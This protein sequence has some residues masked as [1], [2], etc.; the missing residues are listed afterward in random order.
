[1]KLRPVD[2]PQAD[3]LSTVRRLVDAVNRFADA[4]VKELAEATGFSERHVR[5]RLA[6]ARAL[7]LMTANRASLTTRGARLA[8]TEPGSADEK[9]EL[10][11]AIVACPAVQQIAPD[12]LTANLIEIKPLA[13]RIVRLSG[14][15]PATAERRAVVLRAW[16][17]DY[18]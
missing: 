2:I 16:H 13:A 18:R 17:R 10:R 6:T 11:R 12:L 7:G 8:K 15:S 5:Y 1:M 4:P 14:L 9:T 3:T